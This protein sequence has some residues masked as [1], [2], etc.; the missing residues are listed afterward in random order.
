MQ[1]QYS[2]RLIT[3][4]A[5]INHKILFLGIIL[6]AVYTGVLN[7]SLLQCLHVELGFK[8]KISAHQYVGRVSIQIGLQPKD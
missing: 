1:K 6:R 3:V 5:L 4:K 7:R 8:S 2:E